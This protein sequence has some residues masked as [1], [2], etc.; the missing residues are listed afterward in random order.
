MANIDQRTVRGF[1][2]EWTRFDQSGLSDADREAIFDSYFSMVDW[3][4][5]ATAVCADIG[6]GSGRWAAVVAPKVG[7]LHLVDASDA[8]LDVAKR[9]LAS[10]ANV[11]FHR[12]SVDALPFDDNSLDFAYSLGVLHHVP[13]TAAAIAAVAPK[14]KPGGQ[15]LLYL[16]YAFDNRPAWFRMLWKGSELGRAILSRAPSSLRN[17]AADLIA[18]LVYWPLARTARLL[19]KRGSLPASWPL[20]IYRD[21]SFYVMR[22]DALDRFGTR[23]EQR[24]TRAQIAQ[25]LSDAGFGT[26]RFSDLMPFWVALATKR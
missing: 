15:F 6:C 21:R 12:A 22:T 18:A 26:I 2:E 14:I 3:V 25:M 4:P 16:Y 13:D 10:S 17:L 24:F 1:G 9:N 19:D 5:L 11:H 20:A 23:L 7:K 8:A